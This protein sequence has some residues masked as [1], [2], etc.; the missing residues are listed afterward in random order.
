MCEL[1]KELA[2]LHAH[3]W[4]KDIAVSSL[5]DYIQKV[6]QG[7]PVIMSLTSLS[8]K[9]QDAICKILDDS[10]PKIYDRQRNHLG[11][12]KIHGDVNPCNV[13]SVSI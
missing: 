3:Y 13:L 8:H 9:D 10:L 12:T 6:E 7:L 4:Q 1:A 11:M 5:S 2:C